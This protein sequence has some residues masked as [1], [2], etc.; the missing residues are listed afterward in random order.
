[1]FNWTAFTLLLYIAMR[2]SGC[3]LFSPVFGRSGV[4]N[5]FK[6]GFALLL[7]WMVYGV[8]GG[9]SVQVPETILELGFRLVM[10]LGVGFLLGVVMRF[11]FYVPDQAGQLIDT[12]MGLSM[13]RTYDPTTQTQ[14]TSTANLLNIMAML[15]FVTANGHITLLRIMLTSSEI[16][17]FG[18]VTLGRQVAQY[19]VELF[20][21]CAVL[22]IKLALP[23]LGAE[24][25]GQV[26]MG[27]L[28]KAIPQINVF[29]INIELKMIIGLF[30][31]LFLISPMGNFLLEMEST[32][33]D[34]LHNI[35][36]LTSG[37]GG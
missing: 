28:M 21:Q 30:M 29:V 26:G 8:Y 17:P 33:L 36:T 12:Q 13:A 5:M 2:M 14:T 24:L 27:V 6:A 4:P 31:L 10:E 35:L 34:E 15:L 11:F 22:A 16:V 25:L 23:I 37:Q 32:M 19:A 18:A 3:V 7:T 9:G 20:A 1:M